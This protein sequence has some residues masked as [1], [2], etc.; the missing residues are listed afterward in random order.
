MQYERETGPA[1]RLIESICTSEVVR[2]RS[3]P[4]PFDWLQALREN[5]LIVFDGGGIRSREIK[6]TLFSL[7]SLQVIQAVRRHFAST[8][9]PLPVVLVL[10]EAGALDLVT[11]FVLNALQELRKAGLAIHLITQS[12]LD[13]A[14][15]NQFEA[16]LS[17][18]PWQAWYQCLAPADQEL[19][20]KALANATFDPL[21]VHF[22]RPRRLDNGK[23][24]A[25]IESRAAVTDAYYKTPQLHEQEYRTTLA[26]L[27]IGERMVRDR[28]G[29]RRERTKPVRSPWWFHR[30]SNH[31]TRE[32]IDRIRRQPI[33]LPGIPPDSPS[34]SK[35]P[36]EASAC[37]SARNAQP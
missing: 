9:A 37:L 13:F 25:S 1:R 21:A 14:D 20:A 3:R 5:R 27:R 15:R 24:P 2:Q 10:E 11:P 18:T 35:P 33:Y 28:E 8:Q 23:R 19:G 31:S 29:V 30:V 7:V 16:L 34:V 36:P 22:T 6:R 17:H 12:S 26:R 4:G 32:A